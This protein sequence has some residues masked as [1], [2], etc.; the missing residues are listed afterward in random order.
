MS[1]EVKLPE[2]GENVTAGD[3]V[4]VFV[5]V[6]DTIEKD[7]P[8]IE[9]ETE[10]AS[11]EV[12]APLTGKVKQIHVKEGEKVKVGQTILSVEE[13][14]NGHPAAKA[15]AATEPQPQKEKLGTS[16]A[17]A[18]TVE[19]KQQAEDRRELPAASPSGVSGTVHVV[20]PELGENV[21]GG[22]LVRL[23]VNV[24]DTVSAEQPVLELETEKAT[25]EVPSSAAGKVKEI[26][27][28]QG[29]KIKVGQRVL[30][31]EATGAAAPA[32]PRTEAPETAEAR[33]PEPA[34]AAQPPRPFLTRPQ[35]VGM[36]APS[37][38]SP[39]TGKLPSEVPA[40]PS[41]RQL[42]REIGVDITEVQGTGPG[43]RITPADVKAHA[44]KQAAAPA[45]FVPGGVIAEPLPDFSRWGEVERK[46]MSALRRKAAQH[47]AYAWA[48]VPAVTQND[49]ADI[50]GIEQ[51]R[52]RFAKKAETAG[53]KLTMTAIGLKVI[54][55]AM[56][57]FPQFN[58]SL[59]MAKEEIVYKHYVNLGVAVDTDRG[60]VVP[61]IRDV[62]KKNLIQLAVELSQTAEKARNK[63]LSMEEMEGGSFTI[64][65]LGGIG[66]TFFSP[67]I[68]SPDVAILGMARAQMEPVYLDGKFEPRLM[69]PLSLTY[70][71]R[72]I[73][74][75]TA[76]R[77][78]RWVAE[79]FE[80]PFLLS[81]EG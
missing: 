16:A 41:V 38:P 25:I 46:P 49:K 30:T 48:T 47:L 57:V 62:D 8:M 32:R 13:S 39:R 36:P 5:H 68:N 51:L 37:A 67:I 12:P 9:L 26:Y 80:Q 54:A 17:I 61:V 11:I 34:R 40:A 81:L 52:G 65:N 72:L 71:H 63:K 3:L 53:G 15:Q 6:G 45:G 59:D 31:L 58:A 42:A 29:Q 21:V 27:V 55:S 35:E 28:K 10:K 75:A 66:G 2:L 44:R 14:T 22:D 20:V 50:T 43:G 1:T 7:Q 56:R 69:L 74:G 4:K 23:L 33:A 60:L 24:G 70:D 79:A 77:F 73:D 64:T 78:L 76:A 18:P 19:K